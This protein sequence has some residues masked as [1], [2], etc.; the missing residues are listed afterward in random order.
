MASTTQN[1]SGQNHD[2]LATDDEFAMARMPDPE[3][4]D[5]LDITAPQKMASALTGSLLTSLLSLFPALP[6]RH[7]TNSVPAAVPA[8]AP[9]PPGCAARR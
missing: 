3:A 5:P 6:F 9:A 1:G 8:P 4:D 2:R 7:N